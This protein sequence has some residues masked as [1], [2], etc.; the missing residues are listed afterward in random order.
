MLSVGVDLDRDVVAVSQ[1]VAITGAHG[2]ADP[3]VEGQLA[4][5]RTGGDRTLD[6]VVRRS[7]RR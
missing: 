1:R 6:G 7:R 4:H 3:E 2:T 5:L